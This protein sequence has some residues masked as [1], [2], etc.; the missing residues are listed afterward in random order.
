[1]CLMDLNKKNKRSKRQMIIFG[2]DFS[3]NPPNQIC[4]KL[5]WFS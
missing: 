2:Q 4:L 5:P 1:M 3:H